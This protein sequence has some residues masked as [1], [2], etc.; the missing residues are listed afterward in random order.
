MMWSVIHNFNNIFLYWFYHWVYFT[1][2][3]FT[4]IVFENMFFKFFVGNAYVI[5]V[6]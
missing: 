1:Q 5:C 6:K 3:T 4:K 2:Y